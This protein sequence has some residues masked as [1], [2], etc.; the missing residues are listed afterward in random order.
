M[1]K[2]ARVIVT[3]DD[4]TRHV[5]VPAGTTEVV[6]LKNELSVPDADVLYLVHGQNRRLLGDH[7]TIDVESG[8]HFEAIPAGGVS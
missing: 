8:E 1:S 3:I 7:E 4:K 2:E 6:K 5:E